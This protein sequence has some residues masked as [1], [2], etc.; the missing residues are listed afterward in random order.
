MSS[1]PW[2]CEGVYLCR[3]ALTVPRHLEDHGVI[4]QLSFPQR[5]VGLKTHAVLLT[6]TPQ[7]SL[8]QLGVKLHLQQMNKKGVFVP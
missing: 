5:G 1:S 2:E 3:G 6:H 4:E 7:L 8:A